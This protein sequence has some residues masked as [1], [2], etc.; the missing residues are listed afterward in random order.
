MCKTEPQGKRGIASAYYYKKSGTEPTV[1]MLGEKNY[2]KRSMYGKK[3][4]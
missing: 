2:R 3:L 4:L 1:G